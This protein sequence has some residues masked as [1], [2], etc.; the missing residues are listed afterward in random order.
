[1]AATT[2]KQAS[3]KTYKDTLHEMAATTPTR[4][5]NDSCSIGELQYAVARGATGAT[6]N[7]VIVK[8]VLEKEF[9][10]YEKTLK[11]AIKDNPHATEDDIAWYMIE[12]AAKEGAK[13]LKKQ[14]SPTKAVGRISIQTNTKYYQNAQELVQ[15]ALH[16]A[17]LGANMQVKLPATKA[18]IEAIEKV[19]YEGVSVNATVCF[20]VPQDI[21]VA[22]A[23][24]RGLARR[25]A[26]GKSVGEIHPVCTI[27][28]GR[29]DDWLKA[30]AERDG[31]IVDPE[32]LEWAGVAC[33]KRAYEIYQEKQYRTTLLAAAYRNHYHWSEFIGGNVIETIPYKW[34]VRFNKSDVAV[35]ERMHVAVDSA[36]VKGLNRYFTDFK[37]AY[38]PKGL[39]PQQ[40][41]TYGATARTLLQFAAG[42]DELIKIV[43]EV[44]IQVK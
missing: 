34:Q 7:P 23:V 18:G 42:Y 4:Y 2:K 9:S 39:S 24:E 44:M 1:M 5:W 43:R 22:E 11:K 31:V 29:L 35:Q 20:T 3:K 30:I 25:E 10:S 26:E 19:T 6:T 8:T 16:F 15:Q 32:I 28:V 37:K 17:T 14:F 33:M 41:D 12:Y 38:E 36:I 27:M 40:F 13:V 21:A